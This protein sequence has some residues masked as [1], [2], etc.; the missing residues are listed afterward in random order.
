MDPLKPDVH[1]NIMFLKFIS[2]PGRALSAFWRKILCF[3]E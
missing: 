3:R 1:K 2:Y